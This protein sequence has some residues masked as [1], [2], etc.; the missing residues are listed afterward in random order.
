MYGPLHY[1]P[2]ERDKILAIQTT[3]EK[4][5]KHMSLSS[6]AELELSWWLNI[7]V[8]ARNILT[9]DAPTIT[10]TTDASKLG[11]GAVLGTQ[12]TEGLWSSTERQNHINYLELFAAFLGL[13]TFCGSKHDCHIKAYDWQYYSC[14]CNKSHGN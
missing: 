4:F 3:C 9:R 1:R 13:Q 11:W 2:L 10:L 6:E 5:D 8:G 14:G 7:I 12:S